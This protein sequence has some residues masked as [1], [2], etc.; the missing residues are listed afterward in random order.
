MESP[1][2]GCGRTRTSRSASGPRSASATSSRARS[3]YDWRSAR[4]GRVVLRPDGDELALGDRLD[5]LLHL[6]LLAA[7]AVGL[8]IAGDA[9]HAGG[10][11]LVAHHGEAAD[12]VALLPAH[13][14]DVEP[15]QVHGVGLAAPRA[16]AVV[17]LLGLADGLH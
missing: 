1:S 5:D 7:A 4:S 11:G 9:H 2:S 13:A 12:D 8:R 16:G 6:F 3:A 14:L 10:D 15:G 17:G